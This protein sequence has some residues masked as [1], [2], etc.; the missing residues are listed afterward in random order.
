MVIVGIVPPMGIREVGLL[1]EIVGSVLPTVT[2]ETALVSG[3]ESGHP[4][5]EEAA[6][7]SVP[8][9][10]EVVFHLDRMESGAPGLREALRDRE[11]FPGDR[12]D[13]VDRGLGAPGSPEGALAEEVREVRHR[14]HP[15]LEVQ[16]VGKHGIH[17]RLRSAVPAPDV[18]RTKW[19]MIAG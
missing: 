5:E 2:G 14:P 15:V 12:V 11:A 17:R 13:R 3:G 18:P 7:A 19:T 4:T 8:V 6:V 1:T 10:R 16:V 9:R